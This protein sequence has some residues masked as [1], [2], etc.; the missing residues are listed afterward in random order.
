MTQNLTQTRIK[1]IIRIIKTITRRLRKSLAITLLI[2]Y[3]ALLMPVSI[4]SILFF[5]VDP[6]VY[7]V[8]SDKFTRLYNLVHGVTD[9]T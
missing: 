8:M 4:I 5:R 6:E 7:V 1:T 2:I 9:E 3:I